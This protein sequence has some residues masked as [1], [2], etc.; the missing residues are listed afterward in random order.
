M[1]ST[2]DF[3]YGPKR[4]LIKYNAAPAG[5]TLA[6]GGSFADPVTGGIL[7]MRV[8]VFVIP[9]DDPA[10]ANSPSFRWVL[11]HELGHALGMAHN[12][13][14]SYDPSVTAE[15]PSTSVMD[16]LTTFGPGTRP[17]PYDLE[18]M[19]YVYQAKIPAVRYLHCN[20]VQTSYDIGCARYD[21][22]KQD[23]AVLISRLRDFSQLTPK[24][25]STVAADYQNLIPLKFIPQA[26]QMANAGNGAAIVRLLLSA[27][28]LTA[29]AIKRVSFDQTLTAELRTELLSSMRARIRF[30]TAN[31]PGFTPDQVAWLNWYLS[32]AD[33]PL[34]TTQNI[35]TFMQMLHDLSAGGYE[36]PHYSGIE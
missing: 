10:P 16:Y 35:S 24:A 4:S 9:N 26:L 12:F 22:P 13:A 1:I 7:S 21:F 28:S 18:Y 30:L 33:K 5:G 25:L 36:A 32:Y 3:A 31:A 19:Q 15:I 6:R 20:D 2:R 34:F 11:T 8:D 14:G 29:E 23:S 17:F 27:P